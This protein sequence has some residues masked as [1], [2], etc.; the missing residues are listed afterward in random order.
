MIGEQVEEG[1]GNGGSSDYAVPLP[2]KVSREDGNQYLY[3]GKRSTPW[4]HL[5]R[6]RHGTYFRDAWTCATWVGR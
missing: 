5:M 3:C 4:T 2:R 6:S 1:R